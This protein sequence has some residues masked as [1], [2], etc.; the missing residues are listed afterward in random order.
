MT[1]HVAFDKRTQKEFMKLDKPIR[2]QILLW[3]N[4]NIEG[5]DNPRWTG[6]GLTADKSGLWRYRIGKYRLICIIH[7]DHALVLVI[8][9][10]KHETI[11]SI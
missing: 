4:K 10:G 7:D 6:K 8:K 9:S 3:L 5:C 2:Q 1:Y 11:Y